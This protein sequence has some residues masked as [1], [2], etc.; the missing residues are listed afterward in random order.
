MFVVVMALTTLGLAYTP[1]MTKSTSL[2]DA[3]MEDVKMAALME[4]GDAA[5][6]CNR[7]VSAIF[8]KVSDMITAILGL[9]KSIFA[10][11]KR[12]EVEFRNPYSDMFEEFRK[13][14]IRLMNDLNKIKRNIADM[15]GKCEKKSRQ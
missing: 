10:L 8:T 3:L 12:S 14:G 6:M 13:D 4:E 15:Q 7:V 1:V 2:V 11:K 5:L 9:L